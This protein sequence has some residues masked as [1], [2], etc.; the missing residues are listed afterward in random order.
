VGD[1]ARGS[2]AAA[3][4]RSSRRARAHRRPDRP[5]WLQAA[6]VTTLFSA[7]FVGWVAALLDFSRACTARASPSRGAL[8]G[9]CTLL[10][11]HT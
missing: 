9:F 2:L 5:L 10:I 4:E 7:V 6:A 3:L 1:P 11:A 8:L